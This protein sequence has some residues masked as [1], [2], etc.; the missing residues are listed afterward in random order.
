MIESCQ[1]ARQSLVDAGNPTTT[2]GEN[3]EEPQLDLN[4]VSASLSGTRFRASFYQDS[5]QG[6]APPADCEKRAEQKDG[7]DARSSLA[8]EVNVFQI[9]PQGEFVQRKGRADSIEQRHQTTRKDRRSIATVAE[10]AEPA[11]SHSQE[12]QDSDDQVVDMGSFHQNVVKRRDLMAN[13]IDHPAHNG[14]GEK[15]ADGGEKEPA[16][17]TVG[18]VLVNQGA[19]ARAMQERQQDCHHDY[20]NQKKNDRIVQHGLLD[21]KSS[22]VCTSRDSVLGPQPLSESG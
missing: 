8:H 21:R 17:R 4:R 9:Q 10:F 19:E 11:V 12:N 13:A 5:E 1:N 15:E 7:V 2:K 16:A 14:E 6:R 22:R 3:C 20:E 18:N